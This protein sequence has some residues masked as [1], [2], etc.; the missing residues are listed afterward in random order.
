MNTST[1]TRR[2]MQPATQTLRQACD[3]KRATSSGQHH[4]RCMSKTCRARSPVSRRRAQ[5]PEGTATEVGEVYA[6]ET[7]DMI[8][9]LNLTGE[10]L[11]RVDAPRGYTT[12]VLQIF[13]CSSKTSTCHPVVRRDRD[14][15]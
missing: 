2:L 1:Q 14:P 5:A 13:P 9:L 4:H 8:T 12:A 11:F 6:R 7:C 15:Q 3:E 10:R